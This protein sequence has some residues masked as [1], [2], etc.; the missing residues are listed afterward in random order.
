MVICNNN[1]IVMSKIS[2]AWC[3]DTKESLFRYVSVIFLI[4]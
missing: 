3:S 1:G 2:R 4:V